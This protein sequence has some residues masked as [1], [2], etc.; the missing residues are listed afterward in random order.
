MSN[1]AFEPQLLTR[2][3]K[4]SRYYVEPRPRDPERFDAGD[5][6]RKTVVAGLESLT[7]R[8]ANFFDLKNLV[9]FFVMYV[10]QKQSRIF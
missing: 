7:K 4:R 3:Q 8:V 6:P 1:N 2:P 9:V 5:D 10:G